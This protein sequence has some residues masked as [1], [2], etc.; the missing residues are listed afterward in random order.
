MGFLAW[1]S[2]VIGAILITKHIWSNN[3]PPLPPTTKAVKEIEIWIIATRIRIKHKRDLLKT[4][5]PNQEVQQ[6]HLGF[7]FRVNMT[8]PISGLRLCRGRCVWRIC[9]LVWTYHWE[10]PTSVFIFW[11]T[12]LLEK[13][14]PVDVALTSLSAY[15]W[16]EDGSL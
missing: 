13:I 14:F 12:G 2:R 8:E 5:I 1:R 16:Q 11:S 6:N 9:I 15:V 4:V 7:F 3:L 10:V